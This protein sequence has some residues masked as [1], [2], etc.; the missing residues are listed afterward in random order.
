[1]LSRTKAIATMM[2]KMTKHQKTT[3]PW[4]AMKARPTAKLR[5][6]IIRLTVDQQMLKRKK[7][8]RTL[9]LK[10]KRRIMPKPVR[11]HILWYV[12]DVVDGVVYKVS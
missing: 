7:G 10:K 11:T 12:C 5:I 9:K 2:Q 1:M 6:T 4:I 8:K 3:E